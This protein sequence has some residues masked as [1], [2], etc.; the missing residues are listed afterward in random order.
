[1]RQTVIAIDGPAGAGKSTVARLLA[2]RLGLVHLDTGATYRLVAL[3]ALDEG[4]SLDDPSALAALAR[5]V[6]AETTLGPDG[7]LAFRGRP[8]GERIRTAEVGEA[9]SRLAAYPPVRTAMVQFQR[10]LVPPAGAV[11]EGRDIGTVVWRDADVKAY[12]DANE[13]TRAKRR[14]QPVADRDRRD[15][16]RPVGGLRPADGALRIDTTDISAEEVAERIM[17]RLQR[18]QT[19][20]PPEARPS[21]F[22]RAVRGAWAAILRGPLKMTVEGA[23]NIPVQGA[24]ILA[25]NHRSLIDIP[26]LAALTKRKVWFMGKEELFASKLGNTVFSALGGFPVRRGKP[27]RRAL[28]MALRLLANGALVGV[29][30][31][32]TRRP[33][34]RFEDVEDGFAYLALKSGAPIV[35][36]ALIGTESVFPKGRKLPRRARVRVLVGEPFSV[37]GPVDG[38]VPRQNVHAATALA[39]QRLIAVMDEIDPRP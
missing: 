21:A 13:T 18:A 1:V 20:A 34:A 8:V 22:I 12:L 35:P 2:S 15:T 32:G 31:E 27:D 28:N 4:R 14:A 24:A 5:E 36:I 7:E 37:G 23:Q 3:R 10:A 39:R 9:A 11:I 29:Y 19:P 30:P 26:V 33:D 17:Q 6:A 25:P 38:I 16:E